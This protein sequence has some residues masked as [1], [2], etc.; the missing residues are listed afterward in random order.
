MLDLY[1][2]IG[3][4]PDIR[5]GGL[6]PT[7]AFLGAAG[8]FAGV[9]GLSGPTGLVS[10]GLV[11]CLAAYAFRAGQDLAEAGRDALTGLPGRKGAVAAIDRALAVCARR[12]LSTGAIVIEVDGFKELEERHDRAALD[13]V[14]MTTAGRLTAELR[15]T[16]LAFHLEG[17]AFAVILTPV[18]RLSL[19][20]VIQLSARLQQ[21]LA[22]PVAVGP[23]NIYVTVSAGFCLASRLDDP[24]G[25]KVLRAA[26]S[27]QIEAARSG[28]GAIRCYSEA[29]RSRV[30]TRNQLA[31]E[32]TGALGR[33]E[34]C[35][36]FQPQVTTGSGRITGFEALTRWRHPSRGLIPPAEFLPVLEQA[37]QMERL[38][39]VMVL[40][41]LTALRHWDEQGLDVPKVAV[42]FATAELRNPQ[43]VER[44]SWELDRS[45]LAPNR[46]TI[47][48]LE[49]VVASRTEDMVIHNLAALAELG[50][51]IDLDDFGTG[52]ASITN[53]RKF[54]IERIKIDRSFVTRI[55]EDTDQQKMV[56]A[57]LTMAERLGLDT[58]A[59]GVETVAERQMLAELGCG[60]VQGFGIA[61]PMPLADTDDWIRRQIDR[62]K[63]E[64]PVR[65]RSA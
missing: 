59:E 57:I 25:Q 22:E 9:N 17:P 47:E 23:N 21:S 37:G 16:D 28:P 34:I 20:T 61:R 63:P 10:A 62:R 1:R 26:V 52:H 24:D 30:V 35:A 32:V 51:N 50:C 42:N 29:M 15:D 7:L 14:L 53:I 3:M 12:A 60:H 40:Q 46:L 44:I 19:E 64:P 4:A 36:F 48:V 41:A 27:A 11:G 13:R 33:G 58:L 18:R 56:S 55:D 49:T 38:G 54:S 6:R 5:L 31:D 45:G 43:L 65:L 39:E 2:R 8:A